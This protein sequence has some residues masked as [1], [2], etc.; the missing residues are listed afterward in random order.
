MVSC[1][2]AL[3]QLLA[4]HCPERRYSEVRRIALY[5]PPIPIIADPLLRRQMLSAIRNIPLGPTRNIQ[6]YRHP[7]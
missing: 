3:V 7:D 5:F 4:I 2:M 1:S 6:H